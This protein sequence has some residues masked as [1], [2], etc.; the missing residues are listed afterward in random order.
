MTKKQLRKQLAELYAKVAKLQ[1]QLTEYHKLQQRCKEVF[2]MN[3]KLKN[4]VLK[5]N[6]KAVRAENKARRLR[7]R[8][9]Q[10]TEQIEALAELNT[11]IRSEVYANIHAADLRTAKAAV[12]V[13]DIERV[14]PGGGKPALVYE[15]EQERGRKQKRYGV[16]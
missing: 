5:V 12:Q 11:M 9:E 6:G 1:Q 14:M 7:S 4:A 10:A 15:D 2:A 8:L 3:G 16:K 13:S